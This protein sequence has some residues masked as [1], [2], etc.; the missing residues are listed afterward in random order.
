MIQPLRSSAQQRCG[1]TAEDA[2]LIHT[3]EACAE[4]QQWV[5]EAGALEGRLRHLLGERLQ[6]AAA[7][8]AARE[9]KQKRRQ[10]AADAGSADRSEEAEPN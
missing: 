2:E 10:K 8:R 5:D 4:L 1:G 3:R 6:R 7:Q 9:R